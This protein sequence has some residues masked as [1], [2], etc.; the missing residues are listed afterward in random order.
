MC[1]RKRQVQRKNFVQGCSFTHPKDYTLSLNIDRV[2]VEINKNWTLDFI[3]RINI[4]NSFY[5]FVD[6]KLR[7]TYKELPNTRIFVMLYFW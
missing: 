5:H 3:P 1:L 2:S 4:K 6:P 7:E